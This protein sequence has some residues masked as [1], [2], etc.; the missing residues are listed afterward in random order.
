MSRQ[1][2]GGFWGNLFGTAPTH[3]RFS[4][5]ELQVSLA[6]VFTLLLLHAFCLP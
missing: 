6:G 2:R 1:Q 4:V 5:E 3:D